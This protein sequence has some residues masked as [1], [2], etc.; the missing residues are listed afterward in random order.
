MLTVDS[1][2]LMACPEIYLKDDEQ[3]TVTCHIVK[4][5]WTGGREH[6]C[7]RVSYSV[8]LFFR[9]RTSKIPPGTTG[10]YIWETD[11]DA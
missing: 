4:A 6:C 10:N 7:Q 2:A 11:E 5:M 8:D 3:T 9:R 1:S